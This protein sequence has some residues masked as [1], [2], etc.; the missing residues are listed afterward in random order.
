M[1]IIFSNCVH[2]H[3]ILKDSKILVLESFNVTNVFSHD[4]FK[5]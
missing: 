4:V 1:K 3:Q 2:H 5:I